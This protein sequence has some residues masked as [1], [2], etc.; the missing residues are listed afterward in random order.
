MKVDPR[1]IPLGMDDIESTTDLLTEAF[2]NEPPITHLFPG[3]R[4]RTRVG[5]FMRFQCAY[6]LLFGEG[7]GTAAKDGAALWLPPGKTAMTY[8]RMCRA[9]LFFAPLKLGLTALGR[10]KDLADLMGKHHKQS[11]PMPHYYLFLM[12]VRP[13]AKGKGVARLLLDGMLEKI[14]AER[15][16]VYLETQKEKNVGLYQKFGF[17]V[18]A[19]ESFRKLEGLRNWGMLRGAAD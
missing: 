19:E 1:L 7:Y 4:Q 12:G 5:Y 3:A 10:I 16:P 9:G 18:V 2:L 8:G 6:A 17:E 15:L 14:D 13:A 11:A